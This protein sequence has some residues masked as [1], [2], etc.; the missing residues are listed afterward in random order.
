MPTKRI[1]DVPE[2]IGKWVLGDKE[3]CLDLDH[4][5]TA[6]IVREYGVYEHTCPSC[7]EVH[8]FTVNKN[9]LMWSE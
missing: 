9:H 2:R 3:R 5:T 1:G 4:T 8:R 6:Y 7:G